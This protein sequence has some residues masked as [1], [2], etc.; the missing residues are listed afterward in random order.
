MPAPYG[1]RVEPSEARGGAEPPALA[2]KAGEGWAKQKP[3]AKRSEGGG[4]RQP[5]SPIRFLVYIIYKVY[6][7]EVI[8]MRRPFN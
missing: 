3:E 1:V 6:S 8:N 5:R 7:L 4:L 2:A